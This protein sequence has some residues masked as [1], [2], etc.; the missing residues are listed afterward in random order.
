M[1]ELHQDAIIPNDIILIVDDLLA[2]GGTI[3]VTIKLI[4]HAAFIITLCGCP[5]AQRLN[6]VGIE[7]Y[8]L[9]YFPVS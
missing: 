7:N 5:G 2:T 1:L 8:S 6:A 3:E 9:I 4:H